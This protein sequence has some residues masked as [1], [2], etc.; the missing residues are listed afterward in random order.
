[1]KN[2]EA[3]HITLAILILTI[4]IGFESIITLNL[5]VLGFALLFS[6]LIIVINLCSKA[7]MASQLD[8]GVQNELWTFS[9]YGMKPGWHFKKPMPIGFILP[10]I[11]SI[12][13]LGLVKFMTILTFEATALKRRAAKRHGIY[14][15]TELTDWHISL[16]AAGG[17]IG[18]LI[19]SFVSY[20]IPGLEGLSKFAAYYAFWN[21]LPIS[22]LDGAQIFFG[23]RVLWTT[24]AIITAIFTA[25][26]L[27]LV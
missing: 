24:L 9:R 10:L 1:M 27:L 6:S 8:A 23:S 2:R 11:L 17:I 16:I 21:L 3:F 18:T 12:F 25:Y 14:S 26:A 7:I 15:F 13:S 4:I 22:K 5:P 19:L 20:W